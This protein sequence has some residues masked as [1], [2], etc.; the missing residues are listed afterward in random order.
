MR[1]DLKHSVKKEVKIFKKSMALT[2]P[3]RADIAK[4][5]HMTTDP[6]NSWCQEC[7]LLHPSAQST[8]EVFKVFAQG[9]S[10]LV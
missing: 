3:T 9:R 4:A 7:F 5:K 10:T 6:T 2:I 8:S 1:K